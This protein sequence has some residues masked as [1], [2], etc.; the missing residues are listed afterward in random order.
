MRPISMLHR[1]KK[2]IW[3]SL[4]CRIC[5]NMRRQRSGDRKGSRP[6]MTSTRA[7]A[8]HSVPASKAY[9]L[10]AGAA[11]AAGA[12]PRMALKNSDEDGSSTITS[13]FLLKLAR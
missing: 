1:P 13:L 11:A 4:I 5:S 2:R 6:S 12:P 10:P 9:F 7:S 3:P 8:A